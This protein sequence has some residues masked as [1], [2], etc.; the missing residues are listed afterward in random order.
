MRLRE[1]IF[2]T[3]LDGSIVCIQGIDGRAIPAGTAR[4]SLAVSRLCGA[5][6][7]EVDELVEPGAALPDVADGLVADA[8]GD[9]NLGGADLVV[10]GNRGRLV[11]E[12]DTEDRDGLF[13]GQDGSSLARLD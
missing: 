9:C 12:V 6:R 5:S 10:L 11:G 1:A 13:G 3:A 7:V 2:S 8:E 4:R